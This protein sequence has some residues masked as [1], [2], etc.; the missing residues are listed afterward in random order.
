MLKVPSELSMAR[1]LGLALDGV[2][3]S[4][5]PQHDGVYHQP[6]TS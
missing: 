1:S 4:F 3:L 2:I 5:G 6:G